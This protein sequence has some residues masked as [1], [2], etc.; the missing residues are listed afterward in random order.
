MA[1]IDTSVNPMRI[2]MPYLNETNARD[3]YYNF[4]AIAI[5]TF[6]T[7]VP[8]KTMEIVKVH[9]PLCYFGY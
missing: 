9:H 5:A 6:L 7:H 1:A 2:E 4:R 8:Q 3:D